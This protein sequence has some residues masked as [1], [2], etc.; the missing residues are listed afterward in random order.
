MSFKLLAIRPLDG[1][2]PKFLKNL[3]ENRIYQFYNDYKFYFENNIEATDAQAG[4]ITKI[5]YK[6]ESPVPYDLFGDN[7]NIS[8]IVGKNGS[9]K[10]ALVE[11]M[12]ASIVNMSLFISDKF[13]NAEELYYGKDK[14][15]HIEK[16]KKSI[17]EDLNNIF[18]EFYFRLYNYKGSSIK[19]IRI[20]KNDIEI[21]FYDLRNNFYVIER[22]IISITDLKSA[23]TDIYYDNVLNLNKQVYDTFH[24][25]LYSMVINYSHY[26]FNNL[27]MGEWLRGVFHKNDGYQLPIVIN[28]YREDGNIDINS[29]KQLV[30]DRFLVNILQE[31][32]LRIVSKDQM[33]T[34][35]SIEINHNKFKWDEDGNSLKVKNTIK[36]KRCILNKI[37]SE[38][39]F[40]DQTYDVDNFY[41][42]YALDYVLVKL[43][44]MARYP[45]YRKYEELCFEDSEIFFIIKLNEHFDKY[46]KDIVRNRSHITE[47]FYQ[48]VFF[49]KYQYLD[50]EYNKSNELIEIDILHK[51]INEIYKSKQNELIVDIL[52]DI[53]KSEVKLD[54]SFRT[55]ES[56]P[57]FLK[58]NYY[59]DNEISENNFNNFSSGE[60][61]KIYSIHS[62]IYH[63]RNIDSV[64]EKLEING[65]L[66]IQIKYK[67]INIIFDEIELYAHPEFQRSF[68]SDFLRALKAVKFSNLNI[69]ILFITHSPFILSDIPKQNVLFLEVDEK[70]KKAKPKEY[71]GDNTFGENIHQMLTDGFFLSDTKGEFVTNKIKEF[72]EFYKKTIKLN[73]TEKPNNFNEEIEKY[74]K[75]INLIGED[76]V[77]NILKNHL[78]DLQVHFGITTY[79][80]AEEK[81]LNQRLAEI[82]KLKG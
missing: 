22:P 28:P 79:L 71:S 70:T 81:Q 77:S 34:H 14:K 75:L 66:V 18:I 73:K 4:E 52:G 72:L 69:N 3:E 27:E 35:I 19:C 54:D 32:S 58:V 67:N 63:L 65:K 76:Y 26:G 55:T 8:A 60:K 31:P 78:V 40:N 23:S 24:D 62:V 11:L 50:R 47:K 59:F 68:I 38:F 51:K 39:G 5:E 45:I 30:Q 7:I 57:S 48:A 74:E 21:I 13:I 36:D 64:K 82:K 10:S 42:K 46:L 33:I 56:L 53:S 2:N 20:N 29:E 1:C 6:P 43:R 37:F 12:V 41:F 61:Q 49:I 16:Y 17:K 15:K 25:F 44:K 80:D 9:G